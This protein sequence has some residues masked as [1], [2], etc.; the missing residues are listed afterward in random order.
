MLVSRFAPLCSVALPYQARQEYMVP[1]DLSDISM[2]DRLSDY[3]SI[4][5]DLCSAAGAFV[6]Q[7][8]LTVDEKV[9]E[10]GRS[11]RRPGPHV[12]GCFMPEEMRWGH[13]GGAW[14]H[15]CNHVPV[16]RMP[17]IVAADVVGCRAWTGN[18]E[19][20][21]CDDGDLSHFALGE[22]TL[23]HANQGYILSPDCVHESL[24]F[25]EPTRRTFIRIALPV[26]EG[27]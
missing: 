4:L 3:I 14:N 1:F 22:G 12:D 26:P 16:S 13:P 2:P 11:Q 27:E 8:F 25:D 19:A 18:F 9:I 21:P 17:V 10:A 15:Y 5:R 7:A 24:V 23:L 20:Q 6:G